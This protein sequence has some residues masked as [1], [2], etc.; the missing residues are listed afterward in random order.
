MG[1]TN[2]GKLERW[3]ILGD[4]KSSVRL[5][6]YLRS[7]YEGYKYQTTYC[8]R[9]KTYKDHSNTPKIFNGT[10]HPLTMTL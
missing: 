4:M 3:R 6:K 8:K 10:T 9:R 1:I 7:I 5:P 2:T